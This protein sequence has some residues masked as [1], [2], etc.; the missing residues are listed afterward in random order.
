MVV[1]LDYR[2]TPK[3]KKKLIQNSTQTVINESPLSKIN[4]IQW[5]T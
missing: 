5:S 3:I 1:K 2:K 4:L